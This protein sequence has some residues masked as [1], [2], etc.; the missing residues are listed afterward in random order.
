MNSSSDG[1]QGLKMAWNL[2]CSPV[3]KFEQYLLIKLSCIVAIV[4]SKDDLI[5]IS[6]AN[7]KENR[8]KEM[9]VLFGCVFE[10]KFTL[11]SKVFT[12]HGKHSDR[13]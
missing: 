9:T 1:L 3:Q 13:T 4:Q 7:L 12:G 6:G 11:I 5:W 8:Q 2:F 10:P